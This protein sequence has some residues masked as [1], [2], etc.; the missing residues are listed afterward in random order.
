MNINREKKDISLIKKNLSDEL[1]D[2]LRKSDNNILEDLISY[3]YTFE[4]LIDLITRYK[5]SSG[6]DLINCN[7]VVKR[8]LL[9]K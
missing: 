4:E 9:K 3:G 5:E 7:E 2:N 6:L 1:V 8:R